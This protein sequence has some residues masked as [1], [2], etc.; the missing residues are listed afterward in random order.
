MTDFTCDYSAERRTGHPLTDL[1][2]K[3]TARIAAR[4]QRRQLKSLSHLDDHV[5]RDIGLTRGDVA[6]TLSQPLSV[7]AHTEL[8]RLAL[9]SSTTRM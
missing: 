6:R 3:L 7:D 8:H 9:L 4:R 5:L 2:N 1:S